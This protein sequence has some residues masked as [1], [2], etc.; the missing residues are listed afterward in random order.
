MHQSILSEKSQM[1]LDRVRSKSVMKK[2]EV[3]VTPIQDFADISFML[4][5]KPLSPFKRRDGSIVSTIDTAVAR[6][7]A[8]K[9][10]A[11]NILGI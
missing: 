2:P 3:A 6:S 9:Q 7:S 11:A 8:I 1:Y 10:S 5:E 4:A